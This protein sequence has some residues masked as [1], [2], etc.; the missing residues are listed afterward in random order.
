MEQHLMRGGKAMLIDKFDTKL[1]LEPFPQLRLLARIPK[2]Q[3]K[4]SVT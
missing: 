2:L 4:A 1:V 3:S